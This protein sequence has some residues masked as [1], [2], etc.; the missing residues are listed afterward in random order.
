MKLFPHPLQ[1]Q[2]KN[3]SIPILKMFLF[4]LIESNLLGYFRINDRIRKFIWMIFRRMEFFSLPILISLLRAYDFA[5]HWINSALLIVHVECGPISGVCFM[6]SNLENL[7][8]QRWEFFL[9]KIS[10]TGFQPFNGLGTYYVI[11]FVCPCNRSIC[12]SNNVNSSTG[13]WRFDMM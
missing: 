12:P 13:W 11:K 7:F 1:K 5:S 6:E 9:L 3:R 2:Q 8:G 4:F 10:R